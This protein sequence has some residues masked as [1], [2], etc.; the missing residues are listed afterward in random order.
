[1]KHYK[2]AVSVLAFLVFFS[3]LFAI[4]SHGAAYQT[5]SIIWHFNPNPILGS[6]DD[7][8]YIFTLHIS[9][10]KAHYSVNK[11]GKVWHLNLFVP[12]AD[13]EKYRE[14]PGAYRYS[15]NMSYLQYFL[16][17]NDKNILNLAAGLNDIANSQGFDKLTRINF[18]LSFVQET[19]KYAD[20]F[21]TTGFID[22]YQFPVETLVMGT[23]DCEDKSLLLSVLSHD[24][25]YDV[26]L[27]VM[28]ITGTSTMGH[29]AVGVHL[30]HV[31]PSNPLIQYLR[32]S[33]NYNGKSYYYM[34]S[35]AN[36]SL[37]SLHPYYV[38][39]SPEE[40][41]YRIVDLKIV[42]YKESWYHGFKEDFNGIESQNLSEFSP[43]LWLLLVVI[44]TYIPTIIFAFA[45]EH[46]RCPRC[47]MEI[48]EEWNYCPNCGYILKYDWFGR[49]NKY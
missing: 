48:E 49:N 24:L 40:A 39:V 9:D 35:T 45:T 4:T 26:V 31:N 36:Q 14:L 28:N 38:G 18:I 13:Y 11:E 6:D 32:D 33:Y 47:H 42:P 20:D 37:N 27:F 22:Y 17:D 30:E 1:M 43:A 29:V 15:F 46:K 44:L 25:G 41:G 10:E 7:Q 8:T 19:I 23:G 2:L 34:E 5:R 12:K 16:T 3:T 21:Q